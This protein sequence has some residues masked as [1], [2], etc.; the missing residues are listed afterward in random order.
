MSCPLWNASQGQFLGLDTAHGGRRGGEGGGIVIEILLRLHG[1]PRSEGHIASVTFATT[2]SI[3]FIL[4]N[5]V[6]LLGFV[7]DDA[8]LNL[9]HHIAKDVAL[10][11]QN[12]VLEA[13]DDIL[14]GDISVVL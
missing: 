4:R 10:A 6:T 13:H 14:P 1:R 9:F 5:H 3:I 11:A 8:S 12:H 7:L 2:K